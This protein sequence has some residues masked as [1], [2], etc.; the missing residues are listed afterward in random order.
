MTFNIYFHL[1]YYYEC[2]ATEINLAANLRNCIE[3]VTAKVVP[4]HS[5]GGTHCAMQ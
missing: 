2:L 5:E 1:S 3:G 4:E